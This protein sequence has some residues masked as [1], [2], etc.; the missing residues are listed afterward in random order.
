MDEYARAA[1]DF[2]RVVEGLE[3]RRFG[4]ERP[5]PDP[6][7]VSQRLVCAHV[8]SAALA[9]ADYIRKARG[10]PHRDSWIF[11]VERVK[12]PADVRPLLG[13]ALRYTEGAVE[14]L[15]GASEDE[16]GAIRFTVRWGP[17]FDPDMLLEHA[18]CHLLRH[19]RQLERWA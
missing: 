16:I 12:A 5:S 18:I 19:R 8:C 13:E 10:L 17:T 14:G 9:Y 4:I 6:R 7:T 1:V 15:H 2:C 3:P 11:D